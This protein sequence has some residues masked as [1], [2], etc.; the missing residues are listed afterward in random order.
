MVV[1]ISK[2]F[3]NSNAM[4]V[5]QLFIAAYTSVLYSIIAKGFISL[6]DGN[7]PVKK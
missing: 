6:T 1:M 2:A 7:Y 3:F 4:V 5:Q